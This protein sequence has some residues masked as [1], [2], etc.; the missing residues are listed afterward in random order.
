MKIELGAFE[1]RE[2]WITIDKDQRS[3][4]CMDLTDPIPFPDNSVDHIYSS[5]LLEHFYFLDMYKLLRE[6]L[7]VLKPEGIFEAAV[8][9]MR[10]YIEAYFKPRGSLIIPEKS[11]YTPAW[12]FF[13]NIDYI[14]Y[15]GSLDGIHK[16][17]FDDEN[18]PLI[19]ENAGFRNVK[20]R[21]FKEGLD[22]QERK[23]ESIYVEAVK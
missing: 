1:K 14:N 7:R 15:M 10:P 9:D 3:D 19:I 8:P 2:G 11:L 16:W 6:C 17:M 12:H 20:L 5:H 22:M 13:S 21:E 18:L 4:L 23:H